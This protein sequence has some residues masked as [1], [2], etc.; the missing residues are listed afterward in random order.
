MVAMMPLISI[1]IMGV[2]YNRKRKRKEAA[3]KPAAI[4]GDSDVIELWGE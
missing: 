4:Y 2:V 3:E 1:Q